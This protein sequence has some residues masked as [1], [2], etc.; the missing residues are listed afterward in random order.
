[1][2]YL[3]W[4]IFVLLQ[5]LFLSYFRG[6]IDKDCDITV[7]LK[8]DIEITGKIKYIDNNMCVL[9]EEISIKDADKH[10]QL[11]HSIRYRTEIH[12]INVCERL[13]H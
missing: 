8:N 4:Y 9:L 3:L 7:E 13:Q 12:A 10:P 6:L 1:L 11:V 2:F 5:T